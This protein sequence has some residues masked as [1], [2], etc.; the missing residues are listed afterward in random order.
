[1]FARE[2]VRVALLALVLGTAALKAA[3]G[4]ARLAVLLAKLIWRPRDWWWR[5]GGRVVGR[6]ADGAGGRVPTRGESMAG[7]QEGGLIADSNLRVYI[8]SLRASMSSGLNIVETLREGIDPIAEVDIAASH[9]ESSHGEECAGCRYLVS[10]KI[11]VTPRRQL[12]RYLLL[13][14]ARLGR[15]Y[16][17]KR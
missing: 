15:H 13:F 5:R 9:T 10:G 11:D 12:C 1:M 3:P 2:C 8:I 6:W 4:G 17:Q 16:I 14:G 7:F